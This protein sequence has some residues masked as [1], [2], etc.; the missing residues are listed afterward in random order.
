MAKP[1]RAN[2]DGVSKAFDPRFSRAFQPGYDARVHR[3]EPPQ[4]SPRIEQST[5]ERRDPAAP[6]VPAEGAPKFAVS[7]SPATKNDTEGSP[8]EWL[9]SDNDGPS[10]VTWWRRIN[11]WFL[12]LWG[13]G[14]AFIVLGI[15]AVVFSIEW[16]NAAYQGIEGGQYYFVLMNVVM[17]G[18]SLLVA[19]GLATLTSTLVIQAAR[20]RFRA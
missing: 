11:P 8:G 18:A 5:T 17:Q 15:V 9:T 13:L 6:R 20:W 7:E 10:P 1:E 19:L 14:I 3:E 12:P 16:Q 2:S 4:A